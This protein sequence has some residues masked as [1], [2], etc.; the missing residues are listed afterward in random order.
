MGFWRFY[1]VKSWERHRWKGRNRKRTTNSYCT[2][3]TG[4]EC[5]QI[6]YNKNHK[7]YLK[8]NIHKLFKWNQTVQIISTMLMHVKLSFNFKM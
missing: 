4:S 1:K 6:K 2:M 7:D 5:Y 3:I 8:V